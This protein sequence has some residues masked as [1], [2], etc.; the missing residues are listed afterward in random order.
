VLAKVDPSLQ[1]MARFTAISSL[2]AP[3]NA[4]LQRMAAVQWGSRVADWATGRAKLRDGDVARLRAA[5]I[6]EEMQERI[7]NEM[8][9][10][11][12]YRGS[13][14]RAID[15]KKWKDR[16]ALDAFQLAGHREIRNIIQ[17]ND[18]GNTGKLPHTP[19]G[20]TITRFMSFMMNSINKQL[21]RGVNHMDIQTF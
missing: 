1:S 11:A 19:F 17:E 6:S 7:F 16:E 8:R 18:I 13:R 2:M 3:I 14:R 9:E 5:G 15:I 21:L 4:M 10:A 20:R 12:V